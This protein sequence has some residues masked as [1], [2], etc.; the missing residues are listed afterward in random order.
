MALDRYTEPAPRPDPVVHPETD[1][2]WTGLAEGELRVQACTRCGTLRF[3]FASVCH[4]CLSFESTWQ[5]IDPAGTVAAAVVVH[6]ATGGRDWAAH[7]P[8]VSGLVDLEH[9]LRLPGRILCTC[10]D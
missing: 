3:P 7:V 10:G 1:G 9:G 6:R 2:F 8:F 5:P 4:V